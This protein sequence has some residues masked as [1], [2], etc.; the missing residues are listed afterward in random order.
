[1][2][3]LILHTLNAIATEELRFPRKGEYRPCVLCQQPVLF[4]GTK[5]VR[6]KRTGQ[7]ANH[8]CTWKRGA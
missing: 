5:R 2:R 3:K 6:G 7:W 4:L 1:M 8:P